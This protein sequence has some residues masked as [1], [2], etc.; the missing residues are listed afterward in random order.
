MYTALLFWL[1]L[2]LPGYVVTRYLARRELDSG[3]LGVVGV[4]YVVVPEKATYAV[5]E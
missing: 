4:S 3:L 1:F 5:A 2:M